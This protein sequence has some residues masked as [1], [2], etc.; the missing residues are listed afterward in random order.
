MLHF[1]TWKLVLVIGI[2]IAGILYALPN[3]FPRTA[4]EQVPSWLRP[5]DI[6]ET[7]AWVLSRPPNVVV[8][9]LS[10]MPRGQAR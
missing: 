3:V 5:E 8:T 4:M 10:V 2:V 1:Q 7:V 9:E 6:A